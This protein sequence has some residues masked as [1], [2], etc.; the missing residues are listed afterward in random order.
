MS[1][2]ISSNQESTPE[3]LAYPLPKLA[4]IS[5]KVD[6][7]IALTALEH[8]IYWHQSDDSP[9]AWRRLLGRAIYECLHKQSEV[10]GE[11]VLAHDDIRKSIHMIAA[12]MEGLSRDLQTI[13]KGEGK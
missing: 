3:K 12:E 5:A 13:L 8:F 9:T 2:E 11:L 10:A 4:E 7:D 6:N 1:K